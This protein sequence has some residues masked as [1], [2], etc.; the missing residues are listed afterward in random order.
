MPSL[1]D[2]VLASGLLAWPMTIHHAMSVAILWLNIS[3]RNS[4]YLILGGMFIGEISNPSMHLSAMLKHLGLRYCKLYEF[5]EISFAFLYCTG[6]VFMGSVQLWKI[7]E[8]ESSHIV[9]KISTI[10]L[11]AQ[12]YFFVY[13]M[14]PLLQDRVGVILNRE[15]L[16]I[17][18]SWLAPLEDKHLEKLGIDPNKVEK[19]VL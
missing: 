12:S 13:N 6:R 11:A 9:L 7:C 10:A 15:R 3:S 2:S 5:C 1:Y 14:V 8:C 19:F 17:K 16:G 4:A 18:S